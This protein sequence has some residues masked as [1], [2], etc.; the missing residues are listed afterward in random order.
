MSFHIHRL[1]N[2]LTILGEQA[3]QARSV[4]VGLFVRAG[5][6]DEP[7]NVSGVSHFLE[8]MAFKG[9]EKRTAEQVNQDFDR[10]GAD[11]NAFT[12]EEATVYHA[13]VLP[14]YLPEAVD[15]VS[16]LLRPVLRQEDFEMEKKV[17]INE[18]GRYEDMP[19]WAAYDLAKTKYFGEHNLG[20]SI[21]GTPQSITAMTRE[22][23]A[24]YHAHRYVGPNITMVVTG[25]YDWGRVV[26]LAE[27]HCG[28]WP[29]G[30]APRTGAD[31]APGGSAVHVVHKPKVAQQYVVL[32]SPGPAAASTM[33]YAAD[34]LSMAVGDDSGSR[35]YWE[36][37]DPGLAESAYCSFHEY[38]GTGLF[39]T[40][41][42][43]E[44]E[45]AASNLGVLYKALAEVQN[46][47]VT[48][49]E[50][51]RAKSKLLSRMVR[52]SE[53]PRGRLAPVGMCWMY[54]GEYRSADEEIRRYEAV[55]LRDIQDV[56]QRYPLTS[57]TV[58]ALGPLEKLDVPG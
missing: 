33:R 32:M 3:P 4:A 8:H 35:L 11:Y 21:L 58:L 55:R 17:I 1:E 51:E 14:E 20:K 2:G 39:Y 37:V 49:E 15:I 52:G 23:M 56:L 6:R 44:P 18:I 48:E 30:D 13:A 9:S 28:G 31:E 40:S 57:Q 36:L 54:Q 25:Q 42:T 46:K 7:G 5:S 16:G 19:H 29:T 34:L 26:E 10:I 38:E 43:C 45:K 53:R 27:R 22:E 47:G 24:A 41:L 50:L 12:S